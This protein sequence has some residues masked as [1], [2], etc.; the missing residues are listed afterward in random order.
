MPYLLARA[1]STS[2]AA[3]AAATSKAAA[4]T[5][6][7]ATIDVTTLLFDIN[8]AFLCFAGLFVLLAL[9][10][11]ITRFIHFSEWFAGCFFRSAKVSGAARSIR[12]LKTGSQSVR[13][14]MDSSDAEKDEVT[15]VET[16]SAYSPS[17]NTT[18]FP[19]SSP[20]VSKSADMPAYMP[21][22]SSMFPTITSIL[23]M[24]LRPGY[25]LG[26]MIIF[27]AYT[28]VLLYAALIDVDLFKSPARLGEVAASQFP[29]IYILATK[30]NVFGTLVGLGYE[31]LNVFHRWAG[32]LIV[33]AVNLHALAYFAKWS[34]ETGGI[35][36][37][38]T[39]SH[40]WGCVALG[41]MDVICL[42]SLPIVRQMYYQLF[43]VTHVVAAVVLLFATVYHEA[44]SLP[45][46]II[47]ASLYGADRV[48]RM[49]QTRI[50]TAHLRPIP[51]LGMTRIEIPW[52]NA[53]WRAGQHV[54]IRVMSLGMGPLGWMESHPFTIASV[55]QVRCPS[56][57]Q[58]GLVLMC[59]K[60]G[61]WTTR[62]FET[63]QRSEYGEMGGAGRSVKVMLNGPYGGPGHALMNSFSGALLVTGGSGVT[64]ALSTVQDMMKRSAE[65]TSR[66]RVI[67]FVW[68]I[69][70]P[71]SLFPML[72]LFNGLLAEAQS[73]YT[74]L[75]I[76]V[77]YTR[78][79]L[80]EDVFKPF[81]RLPLGLTLSPGRPR[82][83][84]V[85]EDLVDRTR[86]TEGV[87]GHLTGVV[88]GV[89]GPMALGEEAGRALRLLDSGKK[90]AVG[91]VELHEE[92]VFRVVTCLSPTN[93]NID[94]GFSVGNRGRPPLLVLCVASD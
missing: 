66:V 28:V 10:R 6:A 40:I 13:S 48:V 56:G 73:S 58:D 75:R 61:D 60:A 92:Y 78:A 42:F 26:K 71:S 19:S 80:S 23:S 38:M 49:I 94:T 93:A 31:K 24:K 37:N 12:P 2:T 62:L 90:K 64:Y 8:I 47:A 45:Y 74:L 20:K 55:S 52:A 83:G 79:T 35:A 91:G 4:T 7:A 53:G 39:T 17:T 51:E 89:C 57:N 68:S 41:S 22:W 14:G 32:R 15:R 3:E 63:A 81:E 70:D 11:A 85:L 33:L 88:M 5:T 21:A 16:N 84:K 36:A 44:F 9:P 46:V 67:D 18:A 54:R 86:D 76:S 50:V 87:D 59:K 65:G 69:T 30:N 1:N 82:L 77:H 29:V 27:L 25:P 72:P 34:E 43:F